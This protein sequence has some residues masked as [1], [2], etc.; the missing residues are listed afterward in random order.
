MGYG[1]DLTAKTMVTVVNW[2]IRKRTTAL[3]L[4]MATSGSGGLLVPALAHL[5]DLASRLGGSMTKPAKDPVP[6]NMQPT[7]EAVVALTDKFCREHLTDEYAE[8]CRRMAAALCRKRLSPL[9]S[10]NISTW[11]CA[12]AYAVASLNF[13][14]D[15][16]DPLY[17]SADGLSAAFGVSKSTASKKAST[18][19][20]A[21]RI[22]Q[23]DWRW[24]VPSRVDGYPGAWLIQVDGLI[25]DARH[26]PA[27][28]Q[29]EAFRKGYIPY[30]PGHRRG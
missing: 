25:V 26:A 6:K 17:I 1:Q 24:S 10:G 14:F 3:G 2:F 20:Q 8:V 22:P 9:L 21:L 15:K 13:L 30:V 23:F 5:I 27:W 12:I 18:I 29:E 16:S 28:I 19:R 11:A 4:A 7:F